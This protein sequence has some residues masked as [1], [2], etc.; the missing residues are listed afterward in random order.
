MQNGI[1]LALYKKL[2]TFYWDINM[3]EITAY[4]CAD[5]SIHENY[6]KAKEHEDGLL[7]SKIDALL[8]LFNLNVT[9]DAIFQVV[10]KKAELLDSLQS[11]IHIL[12]YKDEE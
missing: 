3:L 7:G 8:R 10:H 12:E 2:A 4:K 1:R 9:Y 5:N 11:L 6:N